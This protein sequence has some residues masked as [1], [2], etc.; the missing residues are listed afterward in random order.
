MKS[1]GVNYLLYS[2]IR[3]F[4]AQSNIDKLI[5]KQIVSDYPNTWD[6]EMSYTNEMLSRSLPPEIH[7][8]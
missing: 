5:T 1:F 7:E 3:K 8:R 6:M 2:C 4:A